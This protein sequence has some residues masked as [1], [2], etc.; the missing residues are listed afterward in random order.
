MVGRNLFANSTSSQI[1][2]LNLRLASVLCY[3][4]HL[5]LLSIGDKQRIDGLETVAATRGMETPF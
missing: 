2:L 5:Y 4:K 1:S 3:L